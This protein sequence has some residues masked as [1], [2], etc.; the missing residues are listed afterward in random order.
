MEVLR[1]QQWGEGL[2][3]QVAAAKD[4]KETRLLRESENYDIQDILSILRH[5][6]EKQGKKT[7]RGNLHG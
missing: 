2:G 4:R 6:L 3:A 7:V 1:L 5:A